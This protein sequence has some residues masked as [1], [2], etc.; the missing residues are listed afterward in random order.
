MKKIYFT[1]Y[2]KTLLPGCLALL[3]LFSC[4]K[5]DGYNAVVSEDGT[6]PGI[7]T[8]IKIT[9][10]SGGAYIT[11]KLPKSPNILYV[12]ADYRINNTT[13]R[14]TKS[15][16]YSDTIVVDGFAASKDYTVVLHTVS[17]AEVK[18]DPVSVT[19]H[20]E[21]PPY[22]K[23]FPTVTI[24]RDFGGAN[25]ICK[26]PQKANIGVIVITP[27]THNKLQIADQHYTNLDSVN[28]SIRGYD[29]T[30]R[31]FGVYIT[32]EW[33]NISDTAAVTLTPI[34]ETLVPKNRFAAYTLP[35]DAPTGFGW[36]ITNLWN[37]VVT[38]PGYHTTQPITP[39][40]WP[41][42]ITFDMGRSAKLSRYT[43]WNRGLDYDGVYY[44]WT[45]GAPK[46]WVLWG[47]NDTPV[48]ET[49]PT[50]AN[51]PAVGMAT[52][53]GWINL[54]SFVCPDKP[55]GLGAGQYTAADLALWSAGFGYNFNLSLPKVRY[56]RFQCLSNWSETNNYFNIT[57]LS[58]WGDIR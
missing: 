33:G 44:Q 34:Y 21:T 31:Y 29:T 17:R 47:R 26:N 30:A 20:P 3:F 51:V 11:Y 27:D 5:K 56:L 35:T 10:Y 48:D 45:A 40:V 13:T 39:L 58:F 54:G 37:N 19:V 46:T 43:I 41:A 1:R 7:V 49:M 18:S 36:S 50:G 42:V 15:S 9:N 32:D 55:S 23:V 4:K 8:D 25:I 57:E 16:Y 24:A 28:F 53:K 12:E 6:K 2:W 52:A 14:Q 22:L 38:T